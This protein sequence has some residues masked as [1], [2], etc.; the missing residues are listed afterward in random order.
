MYI[1]NNLLLMSIFYFY[2]SDFLVHTAAF[3]VLTCYCIAFKYV[4]L[5][6]KLYTQNKIDI[7]DYG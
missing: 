2:F 1:V 5:L 7:I 3:I 4:H 6:D